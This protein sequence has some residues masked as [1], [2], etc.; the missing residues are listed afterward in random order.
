MFY[1]W[2]PGYICFVRQI[3]YCRVRLKPQAISFDILLSYVGRGDARFEFPPYTRLHSQ[4]RLSAS[5]CQLP[6][7]CWDCLSS[8]V[9]ARLACRN[10]PSPCIASKHRLARLA[11]QAS[12]F[13]GQFS[14]QMRQIMEIYTR[15]VHSVRDLT[16][17]DISSLDGVNAIRDIC[18]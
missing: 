16:D 15:W 10:P 11:A 14:D 12:G 18:N 3:I 9:R 4:I 8:S 7:S 6:G 17:S 2:F 5:G 13:H 1:G